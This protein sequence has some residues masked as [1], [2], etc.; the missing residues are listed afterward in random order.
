M[1]NKTTSTPSEGL[2]TCSDGDDRN[3]LID[4]ITQ[5]VTSVCDVAAISVGVRPRTARGLRR[6]KVGGEEAREKETERERER[7]KKYPV[8]AYGLKTRSFRSACSWSLNRLRTARRTFYDRVR[9]SVSVPKYVRGKSAL[10]PDGVETV[11]RGESSRDFVQARDT[12]GF[13]EKTALTTSRVDAKPS[14]VH[15]ILNRFKKKKN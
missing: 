1:G 10:A 3:K 12:R 5:T 13:N 15:N 11:G 7:E 6:R 14:H 2:S 8:A 9:E 4:M